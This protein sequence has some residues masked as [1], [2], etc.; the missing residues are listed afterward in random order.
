VPYLSALEVWSRQGAIRIHACLYLHLL[1][2]WLC[3]GGPQRKIIMGYRLSCLYSLPCHLSIT[4]HWLLVEN[5]IMAY[6]VCAVCTCE[7]GLSTVQWASCQ[8]VVPTVSALQ[9]VN[10][11]QKQQTHVYFFPL[12]RMVQLSLIYYP[13][14]YLYLY[15]RG[16]QHAVQCW[17]CN[18]FRPSAQTWDNWKL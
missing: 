11:T 6:A 8:V 10:A 16:G 1:R 3:A 4:D 14:F 18:Q 2:L 5:T 7:W 17:G 15:L 13:T 12:L 9:T